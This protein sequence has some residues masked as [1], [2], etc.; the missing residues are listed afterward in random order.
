MEKHKIYMDFWHSSLLE[1]VHV[2]E[3]EGDVKITLRIILV[4]FV[5]VT[6]DG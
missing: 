6:G 4:K 5:V 2:E 3:Q 1:S